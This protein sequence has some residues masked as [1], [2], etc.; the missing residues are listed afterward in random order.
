MKIT[1][2]FDPY[3]M[4][5]IKVYKELITHGFLPNGFAP[6][7]IEYDNAWQVLIA[8]K[9]AGAWTEQVL[10]GNVI[11]MPPVVPPCSD[12]VECILQ[13]EKAKDK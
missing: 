13:K 9:M 6:E 11:G 7:D 2:F 3:N 8:F 12:L 10:V 4:E 1:E 5:H